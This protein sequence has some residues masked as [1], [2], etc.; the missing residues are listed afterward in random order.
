MEGASTPGNSC[1]CCRSQACVRV[2]RS[3]VAFLLPSSVHTR[4]P[5]VQRLFALLSSRREEC[6]QNWCQGV[7]SQTGDSCLREEEEQE[8]RTGGRKWKER[9][10]EE[11]RRGSGEE[12]GS[13]DEEGREDEGCREAVRAAREEEMAAAAGETESRRPATE[14]MAMADE[15][16]DERRVLETRE[17]RRLEETGR[18]SPSPSDSSSSSSDSSYSSPSPDACLQ[19]SCASV[20]ERERHKLVTSRLWQS[21][22]T[23]SFTRSRCSGRYTRLPRSRSLPSFLLQRA[24][25][26]KTPPLIPSISCR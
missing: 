19:S 17:K 4:L 1:C 26:A 9:E 5:R 8:A 21:Q 22:L 3:S 12:G 15:T 13:G 20:S 7:W 14:L 24:N 6:L 25:R 16:T 23:C 11:R 10:S 18:R 2:L